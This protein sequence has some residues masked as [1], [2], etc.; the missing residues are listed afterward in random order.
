MQNKYKHGGGFRKAAL[1]EGLNWIAITDYST[2]INWSAVSFYPDDLI[3]LHQ[4]GIEYPDTTY[5]ELTG[6]IAETYK[7]NPGN[8][9]LTNGANEGISSLFHMFLLQGYKDKEVILVGSTYSEY[10]K[11]ADLNGFRSKNISF[12]ELDS[13]LETLKNKIVIIV[14]PN[15]PSGIHYHIQNQVDTLLNNHCTVII[16]ESFIDFTTKQSI[17]ETIQHPDLYII[18]SL[19]KFYGSAGARLGLII[20][21]NTLLKDF[22][23]VLLSPWRISAYDN[24]FYKNT[25]PKHDL[26]KAKTLTWISENNNKMNDILKNSQYIT[27]FAESITSYYTLEMN[28]EFLKLRNI[29]DLQKFFLKEYNIY[30]RPTKDFYGCPE[31]SFRVGL[32]ITEENE[33]LWNAI[34]DIG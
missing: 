7:L 20:T 26:I 10:N 23:S 8:F 21:R 31:N 30:V 11:S 14:N 32:R 18:R 3:Y 5:S 1:E 16:D 27:R 17:F 12:H 28:P 24:W 4:E 25:I 15:T 2:S 19:T 6:I 13:S 34:K 33:P 29:Q 9:L 22:L